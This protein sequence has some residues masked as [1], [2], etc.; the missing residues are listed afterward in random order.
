[1]A[2]D[3]DSI[4]PYK[5]LFP[6]GIVSALIGVFLWILFQNRL[7]SFYPR[8]AHAN[9][10]FMS[11]L[12]SFITGFLMTAV[13]KMTS[14]F[15][16]HF[17]ELFFVILSVFIQL[18]LNIRNQ[19][20]MSVYF[21]L[22][23]L[24][25]LCV[26]LARRFLIHKK[27]P[28]AGFY[29]LPFAILQ[30]IVGVILFVY[31]QEDYS[32]FYKLSGEAFVLNLILGLGSRLIPVVSRSPNALMPNISD[33]KNNQLLMFSL[34]LTLNSGFLLETFRYSQLGS[35]LKLVAVLVMAFKYFGV[36]KKPTTFSY[37]S[38]LLKLGVLLLIAS[39]SLNVYG[40]NS[41]A[42]FHLVYI[43]V[44]VLITLMIGSRVMLAHGQ[45]S[46][47]YETKSLRLLMVG[48]FIILASMI[49]SH[50]GVDLNGL[51]MTI[52]VYLFS[53]GLLVWS[54]KFVKILL[55]KK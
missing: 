47:D 53:I 54:H 23:Q 19:I 10:M 21:F 33:P 41:V 15:Q 50:A 52:S 7:I 43:G 5:I 16:I 30:S 44:F 9:I 38:Y 24:L 51:M 27:I 13:P 40:V 46:L 45:Q 3:A 36:F 28:F 11:F 6:L 20:E 49:R 12:W 8:Q 42:M 18:A 4:D 32:V 31:R 34:A 1:M 22:F 37:V 25:V 26:F 14:T 2:S 48:G 17:A 39:L 35:F 55:G 29:F